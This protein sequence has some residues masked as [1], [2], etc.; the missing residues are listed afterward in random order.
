LSIFVNYRFYSYI[1]CIAAKVE[2][3]IILS[4]TVKRRNGMNSLFLRISLIFI[5]LLY[6][7]NFSVLNNSIAYAETDTSN[8]VEEQISQEEE[9]VEQGDSQAPL[10]SE[11][12]TE[13]NE[14][15]QAPLDSETTT[16]EN[17]DSQTPLDSETTTEEN[18]DSQ[19]PLDSETITE[20]N[21]DSEGSAPSDTENIQQEESSSAV[22]LSASSSFTPDMKYFKVVIDEVPIYMNKDGKLFVVGTLLKNQE[23]IRIKD[24]GNWHKITY[25]TGDAYVWKGATVPSNGDSIHNV[26]NLAPSHSTFVTVTEA[27]VYDNS[28]GQLVPFAKI[29]EGVAYP[30]VK[31]AGNWYAIDVSGRIGYVHKSAVKREF[32][33]NDRYFKVKIDNVVVYDNSSGKLMPVG[34]LLKGQEFIRVKD[35]GNWHQIRYGK[36]YGYVWKEATEP[37]DGKTIKNYNA[38]PITKKNFTTL[39]EVTVYDNSTGALVPF[40]KISKGVTYPIVKEYGNW[41]AIDVSGRIGYVYHSFVQRNF[42]EDDRYFKVLQDNVAIYNNSSGKLVAVG[43]L[44][45]GQE[46]PRMKDAGNWHQIKYGN[47]YGYVWKG[48]TEPSTGGTIHNA[49]L[50]A[51][52]KTM[53]KA[54]ADT[55]VYDNSSGQLVPFAMILKDFTYPIAKNFGNWYEINISG[56]KG[57]VHKSGV[58]ALVSDIVNPRQVYSYY[59]MEI[60]IQSLEVMYP[61]LI[62][63]TVIGKSVDGRNIYAV[64]LG[65]GKNEVMINASHHAREHMTT[66]LVMEML[67]E[68]AE[69]Y[70]YGKAVDGYNV[71]ELLTKTTFWFVPMVNPDGVMLV[72]Q[73]AKSAKNPDY[74]LKLNNYNPDF[75]AWKA[76]IRGVDLNRQYPAH[77]DTICCNP[78][79]PGPKNFKGY[80]PLSEPEAIA[81]YQFTKAHS[82]KAAFAYHSSGEILYWYFHQKGERYNRDLSIAKKIG[83]KTGYQLVEP[84]PNPSGGGFTDWFILDIQNP[85]FTPE[86]SPY[87]YEQP[88]PIKY[89]DRIWYQNYSVPLMV[90]NMISW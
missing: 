57:Y 54:K 42:S 56:R 90:A 44:Y 36:G 78:G 37:S 11:T 58:T 71:R 55:V 28:S 34:L 16:E 41:Y 62:Q 88:V 7:A 1:L 64:K 22:S 87:V 32:S 63:S 10:D 8:Q 48:A 27:V 53:F 2:N 85:G 43:K 14:D 3:G 45:K 5:L 33:T 75:S 29:A 19:T 25:G 66:N 83:Q 21:K 81:M 72:Q 60:D 49:A 20:E 40:A 80:K 17:E 52:L 38:L 4:V 76:N 31:D 70:H 39:D 35:F 15:S 12:T 6:S 18:E 74:V 82:F 47:G 89:F 30:I 9:L 77:W 65:S 46:Y 59:E 50:R 13:E 51:N 23:Y 79:K 69:A 67:D 26:N 68:Y 86:I 24:E 84:K 61:D 73:G